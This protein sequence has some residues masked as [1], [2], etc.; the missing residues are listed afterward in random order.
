MIESL[1]DVSHLRYR[2]EPVEWRTG[3]F[4]PG[5]RLTPANA[6]RNSVNYVGAIF[7]VDDG[8]QGCAFDSADGESVVGGEDVEHDDVAIV[9]TEIIRRLLN[10][11]V[12]TSVDG[13]ETGDTADG[14]DDSR[15]FVLS[16]EL[17]ALASAV[18]QRQGQSL[19]DLLTRIVTTKV[20]SI[21][22]V[23]YRD[24]PEI[25]RLHIAL[26]ESWGKE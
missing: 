12:V 15:V 19:D 21:A 5:W 18:A 2:G 13:H 11:N 25:R 22:V 23:D 10:F 20:V 1:P 26:A 24:D 4:L 8:F 3:V 17:L 7:P 14:A 6:D 9:A 16:P